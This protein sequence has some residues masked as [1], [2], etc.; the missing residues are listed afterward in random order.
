[1]SPSLFYHQHP[2]EIFIPDQCERLIVGTL[3]PPRLS[4]RELKERDVDFCYGSCENQLWPVLARVFAR[5]FIYDNSS[6][7]VVQRKEFLISIRTGI[8]DIVASCQRD[9]IN[10]QDLGMKEVVLRDIFSQL[11]RYPAIRQLIFTGG[12]SKNGPEYFFRKQAR[13]HGIQLNRV[14]DT[15]PREHRFV[16]RGRCIKTV[17]LT[18]PSN[19][20]NRA[21]G[22]TAVYKKRK[23]EV[24]DFTPFDYRVEQYRKVFQGQEERI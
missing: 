2:Y 10:A 17:S 13:E 18:S 23:E 16:Y 12:N 15:Q 3:P 20:A 4:T 14:G 1:M 6:R 22:S 24:P 9:Q 19:A 5:E 8:C 7:A 21:I 11:D